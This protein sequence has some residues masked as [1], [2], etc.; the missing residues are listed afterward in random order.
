MIVAETSPPPLE[1]YKRHF[2]SSDC[3]ASAHAPDIGLKH[4]TAG[5]LSKQ[6]SQFH[7][8]RLTGKKQQAE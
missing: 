6:H 8:P 2:V 3:H 7:S 5:R 1:T 4:R